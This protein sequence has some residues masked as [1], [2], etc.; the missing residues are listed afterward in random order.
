[1]KTKKTITVLACLAALAACGVW[2]WRT[3]FNQPKFNVPLHL[4][5]GQAMAEL[6]L[7]AS[8]GTGRIVIITLPAGQFPELGVQVKEFKRIIGAHPGVT[9]KD[10]EIETEDRAKY[11]FGTG[12]SARRYLRTVNKNLSA[13][14]VVSFVGAPELTE[15]EAAEIK[16]APRFIAECRKADKLHRLFELKSIHAAVVGRFEYPTPIKGTPRT[17]HDWVLQRFQIV[18]AE[19]AGTLPSGSGDSDVAPREKPAPAAPPEK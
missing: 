1:M 12:L 7:G 13:S 10:Y 4:G 17:P 6:A 18:T 11:H 3:Q 2:V 16:T 5:L 8:G 9:F 14:A 15:K 19:N